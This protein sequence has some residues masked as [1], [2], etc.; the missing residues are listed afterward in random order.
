MI[1]I[2]NREQHNNKR[3]P[4]LLIKSSNFAINGFDKDERGEK[5]HS[6]KKN[7]KDI[8]SNKKISEVKGSLNKSSHFGLINEVVHR[9][10][11]DVDC[12]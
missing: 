9:I 8:T 4:Q 11:V 5:S 2:N 1:T 12:R 6:A 10:D 3:I 7:K